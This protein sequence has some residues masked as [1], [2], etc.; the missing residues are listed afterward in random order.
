MKVMIAGPPGCGKGT[1]CAKIVDKVQLLPDCHWTYA[2]SPRLH[3]LVWMLSQ[4]GTLSCACDLP[5]V[6]DLN[7]SLHLQYGLEHISVGDLLREQVADGTP[8]GLKAK[9]FMDS[10]NLV[11]DE[12]VVEMVVDT[13][14]KAEKGWL[15]DGYPRSSSQAQAL[16][17]LGIRPDVVLLI[18]VPDEAIIDRVVGRRLDPETGDIYHMTF[19]P[20]PA[21]IVD[22]L[23]QVRV[24]RMPEIWCN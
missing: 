16:E 15:L 24:S 10:G 21:E 14:G 2:I 9:E 5:A 23:K 13:L 18:N 3:L 6:P 7:I 4:L 12:L 20:P 22:R 8:I 11:P 19:K 17:K 1:Q